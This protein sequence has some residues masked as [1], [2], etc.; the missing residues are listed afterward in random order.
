MGIEGLRVEGLEQCQG[1]GLVRA[2]GSLRSGMLVVF[3][4]ADMG[5]FPK[6]RFRV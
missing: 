3:F 4:I 6:L 1:L 2:W 5:R